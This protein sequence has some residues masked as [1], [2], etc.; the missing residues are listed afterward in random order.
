M[1]KIYLFV[2]MLLVMPI[3]VEATNKIYSIDIDV[4][5]LENGN[6]NITEVWDVDGSDGTEWYKVINNLGNSELTNFT[7]SMDGKML[8]YKTWNVD[9]SL[10]QK[11]GYYGI[12]YTWNGLELC[13][14]KY[15][16]KRHTFT[17]KYTLSNFVFN[18]DDSQVLYFNFI[19][20]L[21]SVDFDDFSLTIS[22]YYEFPDTLDVWGYGHKGYAYVSNGKIEMSNE[23]DMDGNYVVLLAKFP[24]NTFNT[25]N[26]YSQYKSFDD[27][28]NMAEEDTFDYDYSYQENSYG[29][30]DFLISAFSFI[31]AFVILP[32]CVGKA[33]SSNSY[34]YVNNKKI[35]K[36]NVPMFRDI[37]CNKDI[38]YANTLI[39]LNN[40]DYKEANI[41]GAIILKWV[42]NDKISFKNI[43]TGIFNKNTSVIDLTKD[44]SFDNNEEKELFDMM[45][46]ASKDGLLE[47][48]EFEKWCKKNYS[49]F[50]SLFTKI[51]KKTIDSLKSSGYIYTRTNKKECKYKNV[52]NDKIYNDSVELY[53]LKKYLKEF[54]RIN[55][56]EVMEVK[57]WDEYLMFAYLFGMADKVASQLK[58]MYPEIINSSDET[59]MTLMDYNMIMYIN[60]VSTRSVNAASSARSAA[61]SYSSGGGGFS[62]G[63]GGGGSF[64]GG[65][66]GSR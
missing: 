37:P 41:L 14:G 19:D 28:Y 42:K 22:S 27:V 56:K 17:L 9:E 54:S 39:K 36:K 60:N 25:M 51:Q 46:V 12:N 5:I 6:A 7:V 40:F 43:E 16:Y 61:Q 31:F 15:D 34:G 32:I 44:V 2:L 26:S 49:K 64:G 11:K 55:T 4:D 65:G 3:S 18:T 47:T 33:I 30:F 48:K 10:S 24:I 66:G 29:F 20:R 35:D 13:F 1:K 21:S 50:F 63:G 8:T 58:N 59:G 23:D 62:S 57:L 38:Y 45:K 52:M 53:G